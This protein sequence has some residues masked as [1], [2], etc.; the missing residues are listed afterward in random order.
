M[1]CQ[2]ALSS[3]TWRLGDWASWAA[4]GQPYLARRA[5]RLSGWVA[6]RTPKV[7][8]FHA[9]VTWLLSGLGPLVLT[10]GLLGHQAT[11]LLLIGG[12]GCWKHEALSHCQFMRK[13]LCLSK[14][15]VK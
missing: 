10:N 9:T 7:V 15:S 2:L 12:G 5:I 3:Q 6:G 8:S 11:G 4:H 13:I 1:F 14:G